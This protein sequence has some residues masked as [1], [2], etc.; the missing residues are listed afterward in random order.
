MQQIFGKT[1]K[2]DLKTASD[3]E[4][5]VFL[6]KLLQRLNILS[7]KIPEETWSL[8]WKNTKSHL[9]WAEQ[10]VKAELFQVCRLGQESLLC[11]LLLQNT[12]VVCSYI[13]RDNT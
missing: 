5:A 1:R 11:I 6:S 12:V 8:P 4:M 13:L 7:V 3:G 10:Q 9:E 2:F